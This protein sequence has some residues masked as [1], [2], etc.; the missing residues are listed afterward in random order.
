MPQRR[1]LSPPQALK[2]SP[3]SLFLKAQQ[4]KSLRLHQ[5]PAP[6]ARPQVSPVRK[7]GETAHT[8]S[9]KHRRCDTPTH[10]SSSITYLLLTTQLPA[11]STGDHVPICYSPAPAPFPLFRP[12]EGH[13]LYPVSSFQYEYKRPAFFDSS[14]CV[15]P[16]PAWKFAKTLINYRTALLSRVLPVLLTTLFLFSGPAQ[17]Q[18]KHRVATLAFSPSSLSFGNVNVG[19]S[20]TKS[21]TITNSGTGS[22][23]ITGDWVSSGSFH[24]SGIT[25]PFT[26]AAGKST[27]CTVSFSPSAAS[28]LSATIAFVSNATNGS[29]NFVLTGTGVSTSGLNQCHSFQLRI[30]QRSSGHHQLA[31]HSAQEYWQSQSH[32][33]FRKYLPDPASSLPAS[34]RR[35][36]FRRARPVISLSASLPQPPA[37]STAVSPSPAPHPTAI[38]PSLSAAPAHRRLVLSPPILPASALAMRPPAPPTPSPSASQTPATP[39]SPFSSV[40]ASGTGIGTSGSLANT[41]I[42]SGQSAQFNV[43]F[44][45]SKTG[46]V[47]GAVQIVSNAAN[48]P[49]AISVTGTGVAPTVQHTVALSWNASTSSNISGYYVYRSV[50]NTTS[51]SRVDSSPIRRARL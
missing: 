22:A 13:T 26:L 2:S 7:R 8:K 23:T 33:L 42:A 11:H 24:L 34:P 49:T 5:Y 17:A 18:H 25:L 9:P 37:Q 28:T 31:N 46:S 27:T 19:S 43:T 16:P 20:T 39:A 30:W 4:N 38:F 47:T 10:Y 40:S 35:S 21:F 51:Y 15:L 32:H 3:S 41:T 44:S 14:V 50:G 29:V 48:S 45:P 12:V 1:T 6:E 36:F